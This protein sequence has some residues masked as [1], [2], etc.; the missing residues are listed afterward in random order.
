MSRRILLVE[1][2]PQ[3]SERLSAA[4]QE[5]GYQVDAV[6]DGRAALRILRSRPRPRVVLLDLMVPVLDGWALRS[7]MLSDPE[8]ASL[9]VIILTALSQEYRRENLLRAAAYVPIAAS[10]LEELLQAVGR[11][12]AEW[13]S[14]TGG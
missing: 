7:A 6:A 11:C 10:S 4:L 14:P 5:E 1:D 13:E 2:D 12:C 9:P 3:L 8:T